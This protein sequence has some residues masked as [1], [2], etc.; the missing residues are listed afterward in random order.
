MLLHRLE[1][2]RLGARAGAVD[3]VGHEELAEHRA[4]Q[5]AEFAPPALA[6]LQHLGADDISR[7]QIGRALHPLV[8]EAE[9][10]AQRLDQ[11]GLGEAGHADQQRVAAAQQGDQGLLDHRILAE[12]HLSDPLAHGGEPAADRFG[13]GDQRM[14]L[15]GRQG[16][17]VGWAQDRISLGV[18][19][20]GMVTAIW[21]EVEATMPSLLTPDAA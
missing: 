4:R 11:L 12:D 2:R 18:A 21:G 8:F 19:P 9:H 20:F 14:S 16:I 17:V 5:E 3:L 10:A 1:Q 13:R 7:H 15:G 6:F